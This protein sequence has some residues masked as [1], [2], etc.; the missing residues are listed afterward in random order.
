MKDNDSIFKFACS[1]CGNLTSALY[2]FEGKNLCYS[3]Y[4][5]TVGGLAQDIHPVYPFAVKKG[6]VCPVC[7]KG[8]NPEKDTCPCKV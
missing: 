2:C 7:G 8:V 3:C 4:N 6:W 5:T 1:R